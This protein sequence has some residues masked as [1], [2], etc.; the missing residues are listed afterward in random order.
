MHF[1]SIAEFLKRI[2]PKYY[3]L[4]I[5]CFSAL[6]LVASWLA[7]PGSFSEYDNSDYVSYYLPVAKNILNGDGITLH[8]QIAIDYPPGYPVM[9][10]GF[11]F[12]SRITGLSD[13]V[14]LRLTLIFFIIIGGILIYALA[15]ILWHP[16]LSLLASLLWSLFPLVLWAGRNP[17][18]ELPFSIFFYAT[19]LTF[20]KGWTTPKRMPALFFLC[21]IFCGFSMLIRPIALG[22]GI[23]LAIFILAN[24]TIKM[25]RRCIFALLVLAGNVAAIAPWEVW[26]YGKTHRIIPLCN[27]RAPLSMLDGLTFA[28]LNPQG[29]RKNIEMP[30]DV[31]NL[32]TEITRECSDHPLTMTSRELISIV[33]RHFKKQPVTVMKLYLIKALRSWYGTNSNRYETVLKFIQSVYFAMF[34]WAGIALWRKQKQW[35]FLLIGGIVILGYFWCMTILALSIVRYLMPVFGALIIFFPAIWTTINKRLQKKS[36][37]Q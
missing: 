26:I 28:V 32:M 7:I 25:N 20:L 23:L 5:V 17:N 18:T 14:I 9:L 6:C 35:R 11:L 3:P 19:L 8:S 2:H 12:L 10:A 15:N 16:R 4:I 27:G 31:K 36:V 21:G 37:I 34:A 29:R 30:S 24:K 22:L 33:A 1:T 13:V